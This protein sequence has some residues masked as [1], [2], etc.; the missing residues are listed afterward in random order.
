[1]ILVGRI[2]LEHASEDELDLLLGEFYEMVEVAFA[3]LIRAGFG[4]EKPS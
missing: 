1:M 2:A 4:R 3:P